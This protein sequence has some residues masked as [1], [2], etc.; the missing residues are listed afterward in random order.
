MVVVDDGSAE[1][2]RFEQPDPRLVVLRNPRALGATA[3]CNA[4]LRLAA[5]AG[6]PSPTTTTSCSR[7]WSG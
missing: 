6:S 4:G 2:V 1:P 5:G 7:T 3:A